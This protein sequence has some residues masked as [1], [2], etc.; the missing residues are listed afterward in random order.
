MAAHGTVVGLDV[1]GTKLLARALD[2][3]RPGVALVER[4]VATP[5]GAAA[6][7]DALEAVVASID[8]ELGT[9]STAVGVGVPGLVSTD[10]VLRV[11]PNLPG[12]VDLPVGAEL[13]RRL[14]RPVV[15]DNDANCA[16]WAEA[17]LGAGHGE[18][19]VVLVTLGTGIGGAVVTAGHLW[20]GARGFAGEPGHM[21]VDPSGPRCPCGRSGCWERYASGTGLEYL[22]RQAVGEGRADGL[23]DRA[24]GDPS[25]ITG[26]LVTAAARAGEPGAVAV[27]AEFAGWLALGLANLADVLDPAVLVV[28]GGMADEADLFVDETRRRFAEEVLGGARRE[29]RIEVALLGSGAGA[30][31]AALLAAEAATAVPPAAG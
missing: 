13:S 9:P 22:A 16:G 11:A 12:V 7:L 4:R 24:G 23:L 19:D 28:G 17:R 8:D 26:E 10:G 27:M 14:G 20:R 5:S 18:P 1:G 30:T 3:A 25:V 21:V 31:G 6:L 2:P 29:V 15:V